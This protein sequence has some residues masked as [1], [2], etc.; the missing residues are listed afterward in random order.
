MK[1]IAFI[2]SLLLT[3]SAQAALTVDG[4]GI[5]LGATGVE[6]NGNSYTVDFVEDSCANTWGSCDGNGSFTWTSL[7]DAQAAHNALLDQVLVGVFDESPDLTFGCTIASVCV[8]FTPFSGSL[9]D[10]N[11][12]GTVL[13]QNF[14]GV[15]ADGFGLRDLLNPLTDT[16]F[17]A[18]ATYAQWTLETTEVP[19]PG[20]LGLFSFALVGLGLRKF[21]AA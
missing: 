18:I 10:P 3:V 4:N 13:T 9:G 14:A 2:F 21:K 17:D 7:A 19:L 11:M 1:I 12:I 16:S 5:L 6:V 15:A 20:A 8:V